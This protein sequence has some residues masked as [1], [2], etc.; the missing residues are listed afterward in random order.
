MNIKLKW[1]YSSEV[2]DK[3]TVYSQETADEMSKNITKF[4]NSDYGVGITE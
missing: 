1:E 2:I 3:Y 4:A